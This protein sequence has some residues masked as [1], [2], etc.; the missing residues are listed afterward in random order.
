MFLF[1]CIVF[2]SIYLFNRSAHSA[3][4]R[5]V[6]QYPLLNINV[7]HIEVWPGRAR[8]IPL[9][10]RYTHTKCR[11]IASGFFNFKSYMILNSLTLI[12]MMV[13]IIGGP[14]AGPSGTPREP[15]GAHLTAFDK[16]VQK[17]KT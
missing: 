7:K 5:S 10:P 15:S 14:P 16:C 2:L 11:G 13:G 3:E 1:C 6:I 9:H 12:W 17:R 4:P 8:H